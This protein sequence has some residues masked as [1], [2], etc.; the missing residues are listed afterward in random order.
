LTGVE[1]ICPRCGDAYHQGDSG[2]D[3]VCVEK[4]LMTLYQLGVK[5]GLQGER[6]VG[7]FD[8]LGAE[9]I[10]DV[11]TLVWGW[12]EASRE[13]QRE[14]QP[15][16]AA[17][18]PARQRRELDF[19]GQIARFL[20]WENI[21]WLNGVPV[22]GEAAWHD[23]RVIRRRF[24]Q[25]HEDAA[26]VM[27]HPLLRPYAVIQVHRTNGN[28]WEWHV[29]LRTVDGGFETMVKDFTAPMAVCRAALHLAGSPAV[30]TKLGVL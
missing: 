13:R 4:M 29:A 24:S 30:R 18:V 11:M 14:R 2:H 22:S 23:P 16:I 25:V 1:L 6:T 3:Y 17:I 8:E 12:R 5:R 26:V 10:N 27:Q 19:D 15:E 20:G 28:G 7:P 21:G 9:T